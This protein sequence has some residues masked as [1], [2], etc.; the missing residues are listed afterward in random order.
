M[1]CGFPQLTDESTMWFLGRTLAERFHIDV[2]ARKREI[3]LARIRA[4]RRASVRSTG[5]IEKHH[6]REQVEG[7]DPAG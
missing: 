4:A 6:D 2:E 3:G 5:G 1:G 7:H